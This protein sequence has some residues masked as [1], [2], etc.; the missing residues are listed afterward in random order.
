MNKSPGSG[1]T[2]TGGAIAQDDRYGAL[3]GPGCHP[4]AGLPRGRGD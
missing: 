3:T 4:I 2:M 1:F